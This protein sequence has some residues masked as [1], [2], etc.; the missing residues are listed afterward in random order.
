MHKITHIKI[1]D[2]KNDHST[3]VVFFTYYKSSI[4]KALSYKS[5]YYLEK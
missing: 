5:P 3:I 4:K 1:I 2:K